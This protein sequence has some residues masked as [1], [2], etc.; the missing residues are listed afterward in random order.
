MPIQSNVNKI[1]KIKLGQRN[2]MALNAD[3]SAYIFQSL[4]GNCARKWN[5]VGKN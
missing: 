5:R 2:M 1:N 3:E 4:T